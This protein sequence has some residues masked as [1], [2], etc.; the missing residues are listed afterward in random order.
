MAGSITSYNIS[1]EFVEACD[2]FELCPCWVDDEPDEGHCTGLVAWTVS[3]TIDDVAILRRHV[4]AVTGHGEGR[5]AAKSVS[6]LFVD[7]G[8][9]PAEF[10]KLAAAFSGRNNAG[11]GCPNERIPGTLGDL[12]AVTGLLVGPP[13]RAPITVSHGGDGYRVCVGKPGAELVEATGTPLRFDGRPTPLTLDFTALHK[14]LQITGPA[15]AQRGS[16]LNILMPGLPGGF[17]EVTTRSGMAGRFSYQ[18][19][20]AAASAIR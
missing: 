3:G 7:D 4:V 15:A 1:G 16:V 14:E 9:S 18:H 6:V 19:E 8:A 5:R 13:S 17:L 20:A 11:P 10:T 2:C 12:A